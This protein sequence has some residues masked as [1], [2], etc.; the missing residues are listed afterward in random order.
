MLGQDDYV[1]IYSAYYVPEEYPSEAR[2][3]PIYEQQAAAIE[4]NLVAQ[5][6]G[7]LWDSLKSVIQTLSPLATSIIKSTTGKS[8]STVTPTATATV[9]GAALPKIAG[10]N[11]LL[12]VGIGVGA[13]MFLRRKKGRGR[14]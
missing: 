4:A 8:I 9:P 12:L 1:D 13:F 5:E 3:I 10:F 11:P 6:T 2:F 14:R 7:S